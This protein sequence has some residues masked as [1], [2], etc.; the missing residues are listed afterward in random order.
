M[1]GE[2]SI[3]GSCPSSHA[4]YI[5]EALP[6]AQFDFASIR[7]PLCSATYVANPNAYTAIGRDGVVQIDYLGATPDVYTTPHSISHTYLPAPT[8]VITIPLL[9]PLPCRLPAHLSSP[10]LDASVLTTFPGLETL[11]VTLN[12][13]PLPVNLHHSLFVLMPHLMLISSTSM[14]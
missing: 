13:S 7:K 11:C 14:S 9:V 3:A 5:V 6:S 1:S 8:T 10:N 12:S 2:V 4:S